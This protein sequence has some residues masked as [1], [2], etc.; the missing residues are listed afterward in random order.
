MA[1]IIVIAVV[2]IIVLIIREGKNDKKVYIREE[3]ISPSNDQ[4][5]HHILEDPGLGYSYTDIVGMQYRN[6]SQS[7]IGVH[8]AYAVA[9]KSNPHD[10]YAVGIYKKSNNKLVA[11]IPRDFRGVSNEI[12]HIA[13]LE[14]G[15][16]VDARY[17]IIEGSGGR[18]YGNAYVQY[19]RC[20]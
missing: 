9:E 20:H 8:E 4:V 7:D 6:L 11:F 13:I 12:V 15:G 17:K 10:K 5:A 3:P 2:L 19:K 18:L 14:R 1:F 16:S